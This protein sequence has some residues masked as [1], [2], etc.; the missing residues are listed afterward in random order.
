MRLTED[1]RQALL[2]NVFAEDRKKVY[3]SI[4][5]DALI[6]AYS[7]GETAVTIVYRRH[8]PGL[9]IRWLKATA[10]IMERP[11]SGELIA[12]IHSQ[13][14]D[15]EKKDQ[16]AIES[17]MDEEIEY[18][19]VLNVKS[20][21]AHVVQVR[22][23]ANL[24]QHEIFDFNKKYDEL[25]RRQVID[26]DREEC[27]GFFRI[28][29]IV[30][31]LEREPIIKL[32]YRVI[33][34]RNKILRKK[35]RAFYLDQTR[36][37]IVLIRRDITDLYEEEQRQKQLL[38]K[39]VD[40]AVKANHAKSDFLSRMSH[41]MRTPLNAV[42]SFSGEEMVE[43]AS[44]QR[45]R[46]YL[47]KIHASGEYLLGIINDVLDVSKIEQKKMVL[48]K[49]SYSLD[50]FVENINTVIGSSCKEKGIE[51]IIDRAD[52]PIK[53]IEVD[54][55]RFNQ[56]FI[57]LL[58]NAVKF[59]PR[60]GKVLFSATPLCELQ[61]GMHPIR[62]VV[63]D[64]GIGMAP[65]FLPRAFESFAQEY[66]EHISEK[67]QGTGLGLTIVKEI[68]TL[69]N[70][71]ISVESKQGEGTTFIVELPLEFI[72]DPQ[73]VEVLSEDESS[74]DGM[75]ILLCEDNEINTEIAVT[76][77]EKQGCIVECAENGKIGLEMFLRSELGYY[78]VILMD[79][80]MPVMNGLVA[81][82]KIRA[83]G[84]PDA[85]LIPIIAMTADAFSEDEEISS[86]AGMNEHLSK[87][88]EPEKVFETL[89]RVVRK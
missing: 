34:H 5:A 27:K 17:I 46:D 8:L 78:D 9:G 87:P 76:L 33:D 80:R 10:T 51:F 22:D 40:T 65:E 89:R 67:I 39:A 29:Q 13:N 88:I 30:A 2:E 28:D 18:V 1:T 81:T 50:D 24:K 75:H 74:L 70:G 63:Q 25:I 86:K 31:A 73:V 45:L 48:N 71:T 19:M 20:G 58:S 7:R 52:I 38:Q 66:H 21:L 35:T 41:D 12:F 59:T 42:L 83:S 57:N 77:L 68:V 61:E 6:R 79:I 62:F 43:G 53:W 47:E 36:E 69:M 15:A 23:F 56:I 3:N 16:L 26:E 11:S 37:E 49:T 14:I 84:R 4:F 60:G 72:K 54:K 44:E 64:N 32:T 82:E 55:V 85:R